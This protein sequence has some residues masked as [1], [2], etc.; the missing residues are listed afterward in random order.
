MPNYQSWISKEESNIGMYARIVIR[1]ADMR[2][3][4]V[5]RVWPGCKERHECGLTRQ[6]NPKIICFA[7]DGYLG[8]QKSETERA[9][10]VLGEFVGSDKPL[11]VEYASVRERS[12]AA[13]PGEGLDRPGLNIFRAMTHHAMEDMPPLIEG[14]RLHRIEEREDIIAREIVDSLAG[15]D[16]PVFMAVD[17]SYLIPKEYHPANY[18]GFRWER[19]RYFLYELMENQGIPHIVFVDRFVSGLSGRRDCAVRHADGYTTE[20]ALN[21]QCRIALFEFVD[22][23]PELRLRVEGLSSRTL[24]REGLAEGDT[25]KEDIA[26]RENHSDFLNTWRSIESDRSVLEYLAEFR[27]KEEKKLAERL[28]RATGTCSDL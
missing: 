6:F 17:I 7:I 24:E 27:A 22:S 20:K 3:Y 10:R 26:L 4:D 8:D 1:H 5:A 23:V 13:D 28:R 11:V 21:E 9:R 12:A 16:G 25:R 19:D 15:A 14:M 18:G 2:G